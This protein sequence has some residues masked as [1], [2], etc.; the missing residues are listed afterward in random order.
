M[1][2]MG[3]QNCFISKTIPIVMQ[4]KIASHCSSRIVSLL[5]GFV[6]HIDKSFVKPVLDNCSLNSYSSERAFTILC[7]KMA[8]LTNTCTGL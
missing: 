1:I 6:R 3:A 5:L 8:E 7:I 4:Y 2:T